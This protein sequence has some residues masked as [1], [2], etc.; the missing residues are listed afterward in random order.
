MTGDL[1]FSVLEPFAQK[2]PDR[3][4]NAGIAE[5]NMIGVAAGL[6]M[7]GKNVF[8]YSI[9]PFDTMRCLEQIRNDLC[10]QKLPVKIIGVG[11]GFSYG[12]M[13]VTHHAIEDLAIMRALPEMTIVA[14]GSRHEIEQLSHS[15]IYHTSGP[16]YI[17]LAACEGKVIYPEN[18][19]ITLNKACEVITS[20]KAL[21]ITTSNALDLGYTICT[22]LREKDID[23]GL[24]SIHTLKPFDT[25]Y[26]LAKENSIKAIFTL[27][28][29]NLSC[30]L[31][32]LFSHNVIAKL[33][34][35]IIFQSFGI[36]D[37]YSHE[38]GSREYLQ[39]KS[40]L[41]PSV[42]CKKIRELY[43]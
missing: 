34:H 27:E 33:S 28:E 36:N 8:V 10:Y 41:I 16:I 25:E 24:V 35:K 21:I 2:F 15:I 7:S 39:E 31:G 23:I 5:Q 6:S 43:L 4:I 9:I 1:G 38:T 17:R 30:G 26:F 20:N 13:G 37:S 11:G 12:Q 3:F 29:H 18:L 14:P 32:E 22:Q 40:G 42:I 19:K